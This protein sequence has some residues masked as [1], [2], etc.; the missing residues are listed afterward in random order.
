MA[1][2]SDKMSEEAFVKSAIK[3]LRT[4]GYRGIHTVYSGFNLAFRQYFGKDADPVGATAKLA[5]AGKIVIQRRK[6]GVMLYLPGEEPAKK[7]SGAEALAK[8]GL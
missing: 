7:D 2:K 3:S 5:E 6:G 8:M 4:G 1:K